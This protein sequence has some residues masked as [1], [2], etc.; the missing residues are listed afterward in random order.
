METAGYVLKEQGKFDEAAAYIQQACDMHRSRFSAESQQYASCLQD[1]AWVR[2]SQ[3]QVAEAERLYKESLAKL[4]HALGDTNASVAEGAVALGDILQRQ[5][6]NAE[7]EELFVE[8]IASCRKDAA[9]ESNLRIMLA[10]L[11][12]LESATGRGKEAE[13]TRARGA[14]DCRKVSGTRGLAGGPA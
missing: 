11:A 3:E 14:A 7:A 12:D 13:P 9:G 4:R 10:A 2:D 6:K 8:L 1:L 5:R